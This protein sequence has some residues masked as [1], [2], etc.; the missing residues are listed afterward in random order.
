V[1]NFGCHSDD[2]TKDSQQKK[3]CPSDKVSFFPNLLLIF[4]KGKEKLKKKLGIRGMNFQCDY[5]PFT[6]RKRSAI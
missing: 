5:R 6:E 4:G 3:E 1:L 2:S